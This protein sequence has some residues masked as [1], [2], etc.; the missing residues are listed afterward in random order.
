MI[1]F[2]Q[3]DKILSSIYVNNLTISEKEIV[4][5]SDYSDTFFLTEGTAVLEVYSNNRWEALTVFKDKGLLGQ[6]TFSEKTIFNGMEF[7]YRVKA[8]TTCQVV[9]VDTD[10]LMNHMYVVPKMLFDYL[11]TNTMQYI[12]IVDNYKLVRHKLEQRL[13]DLLLKWAIILNAY[14]SDDEIIFP[15]YIKYKM[16]AEALRSSKQRVYNILKQWEDGNILSR[17]ED[18]MVISYLGLSDI[19][20]PQ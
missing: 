15:N 11:E 8:L 7:E 10:Y 16:L 6:E 9:R 5:S 14:R 1:D 19:I 18:N 4:Y 13:A 2:L 17:E 12:M 20:Y 3:Q